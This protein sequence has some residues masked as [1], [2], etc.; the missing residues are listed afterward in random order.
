MEQ[1]HHDNLVEELSTEAPDLYKNFIRIDRGLF[2]EIGER[3]TPYIEK[4][5][6]YWRKSIKPGL[7]VAIT[8]RFLAMGDSYKS[9]Q[10]SFWV[11]HNTISYIIPETC[12]GIV[13]AFEDE[14]L[15][16][17][18]TPEAWQEVARVFEEWWNFPHVIGAIYGKHIKLRNPP[19][20]GMHYF[21][22]KKF[23]SMTRLAEM[24]LQE[25]ANLPQPEALQGQP[26]GSHVDYLLVGDDAFPLRNYLMKPYTKR[27]L[28]R[29]NGFA[30]TGE[31]GHAGWWRT[32]S[33]F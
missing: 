27:G 10:Y 7:R 6:T 11:A 9:L 12:R 5:L 31:V 1:G 18:Q 22:Y 23:Y 8:L 32:P 30:T 3:V 4:K 16:V 17:P 29:R 21:N 33:G 20:G 15:Q 25:G 19:R 26:N 2:N 28:T 24:L 13:A 14:E